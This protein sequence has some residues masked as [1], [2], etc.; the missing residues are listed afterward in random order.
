ML[1]NRYITIDPVQGTDPIVIPPTYSK[2]S[3]LLDIGSECFYNFDL[4]NSITNTISFEVNS[5]I[6]QLYLNGE[7]V[8]PINQYRFTSRNSITAFV[9]FKK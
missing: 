5:N 8:E 2:Y 6:L 1:E 7:L 9:E 3:F 4:D